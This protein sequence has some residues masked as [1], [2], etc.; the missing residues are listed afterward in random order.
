MVLVVLGMCAIKPDSYSTNWRVSEITIGINDSF[1][2]YIF[3]DYTTRKG[4]I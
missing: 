3:I 1:W 2:I 4:N